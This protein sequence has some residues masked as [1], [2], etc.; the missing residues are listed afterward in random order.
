VLAC[1]VHS[2]ARE[3]REVAQLTGGALAAELELGTGL[4]R[5]AQVGRR[6]PQV[7]LTA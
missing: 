4:G 5:A 2:T 7:G 3:E 1:G 6:Q